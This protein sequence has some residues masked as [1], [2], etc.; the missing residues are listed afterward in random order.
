MET[1][2]KALA[3]CEVGGEHTGK[4]RKEDAGLLELLRTL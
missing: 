3:N 2:A 4:P 1:K